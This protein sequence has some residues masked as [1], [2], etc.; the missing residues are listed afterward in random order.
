MEHLTLNTVC[1]LEKQGRKRDLQASN[2]ICRDDVK[3]RNIVQLLL[4]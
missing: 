4:N 3:C 2:L 1:S